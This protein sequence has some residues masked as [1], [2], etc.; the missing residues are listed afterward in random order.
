MVTSSVAPRNPAGCAAQVVGGYANGLHLHA[1]RKS[2]LATR[3][4]APALAVVDDGTAQGNVGEPDKR[5]LLNS[6]GSS[7]VFSLTKI[8]VAFVPLDDCGRRAAGRDPLNRCVR[9]SAVAPNLVHHDLNSND[10]IKRRRGGKTHR[11]TEETVVSF[12]VERPNWGLYCSFS[13]FRIT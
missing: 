13:L 7:S 6:A 12:I 10:A 2:A 9:C 3:Q 11:R 8:G 5:A 1:T 4:A